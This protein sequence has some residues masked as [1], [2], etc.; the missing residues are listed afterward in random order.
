MLRTACVLFLLFALSPN[1]SAQNRSDKILITLERTECFGPCP[2][3]KLT[4]H[5]DGTVVYEGRENVRV[6]G[7]EHTK[8]KPLEVQE[9]TKAFE[10][11]DYFNLKDDYTTKEGESREKGYLCTDTP[12]AI[13][14]LAI[15][16]HIK[17]IENCFIGP[18]TLE[19]L[20]NR[21]DEVTDSKRWVTIDA[22]TVH[23]KHRQGWDIRGFEAQWLLIGAA[24]S[25]DDEV[26]KSF[27]QEGANVNAPTNLPPLQVAW[28]ARVVKL[29][30]AAGANVNAAAL[31]G[32][33]SPLGHAAQTGEADSIDALIKAGAKVDG[34]SSD[35]A[36]PLMY[37]AQ[38][39]SPEAVKVLLKAGADPQAK[40]NAGSGAIKYAREG[41][42]R[43]IFD[44]KYPSPFDAIV[45]D[46]RNQY[47]IIEDLLLAAGA[48]P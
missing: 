45:P 38:R 20:E 1:T 16:S 7:I 46:F 17:T 41:L 24:R 2:I 29:L 26:V 39:C 22:K 19:K 4:I 15:G 27:I 44:E 31:E 40:D 12:T 6:K 48:T 10:N 43:M 14:S 8:I 36:T 21:I 33:E 47:K 9:L 18:E 37:A 25:G 5:G 32:L 28:G 42:D 35:G 34:R 13:M 30:I 11:V 23:A 3:Y